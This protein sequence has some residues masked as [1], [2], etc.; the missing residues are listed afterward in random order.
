MPQASSTAHHDILKDALKHHRA[1]CL[2]EA[3]QRYE[4]ILSAEPDHADCLHLLG[5]V[6]HQAG[7]HEKAV[8]LIR[9]AIAIHKTAASYYSNL[10]NVL[11]AQQKVSE[12]EACYRQS[13]LLRPDQAEVHLNLGNIL[14]AQGEV[15]AALA[16][17]QRALSLS[18][19]LAEAQAAESTA[20]LL[21]GEFSKG[22]RGFEARWRTQEYDTQFRNYPQPLWKGERL[23]SGRVLIWGEQGV[24]DEVMFAGLIRDVLAGG[25][26]CVL[27]CDIRL[28]PLFARSFPDVE[29]VSGYDPH[30]QPE[31]NIVAHLPSGSL[32]SL[33]RRKHEDFASTI[34]PYLVADAMRKEQFRSRYDDGRPLVGIAWHTRNKQS[35]YS[36][37]IDLAQ[38]RPLLSQ[39]WVRWVSLQ[40]GNHV[41][42]KDQSL[43]AAAP[44]LI[45]TDV[46]QLT[47]LDTFAVQVAAMDLVVTIDNSTAHL[48]AALGTPTWTLLPFAPDWRWL[49]G[50]KDSPWYPAIRLFRQPG[51]GDWQSV[52]EQVRAALAA[53]FHRR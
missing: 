26:R 3:A 27:D 11:R 39:P 4:Q 14:K 18:P 53:T 48:A 35:G 29:I 25:T 52:I 8:E 40:Y 32:P 5:M 23:A 43:A 16:C 2:H 21:N 22:W 12:A 47:D 34:S 1:G 7:N 36:R 51:P 42:L 17:Y 45:D 30:L 13:L 31:L 10:G 46:D 41:G 20:L 44:L 38:L 15:D 19:E 6:A 9:R 37:S 50:R 49:L 28:K 33:F 24:G